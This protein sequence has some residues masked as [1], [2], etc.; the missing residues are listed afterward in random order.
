[1]IP[2]ALLVVFLAA[3]CDSKSGTVSGKVTYKGEAVPG[4]F[5][6]IIPETG[7]EKGT[8]FSSTIGENG[9]YRVTGVPVGPAQVLIRHP[10]GPPTRLPRPPRKPYPKRYAT[11]EGSDLKFTVTSGRQQYDI[12]LKP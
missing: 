4:G 5:V 7:P 3:G 11:A 1:L 2:A 10:G 12:D 9:E 8:V 6:D